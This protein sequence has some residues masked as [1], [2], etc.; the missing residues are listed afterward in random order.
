ME[1]K[2]IVVQYPVG[3]DLS[4]DDY[5]II[6]KESPHFICFPE[7]YFTKN[8]ELNVKTQ[9]GYSEHFQ[10]KIKEYSRE[11]NC[12]IIGGSMI[13]E[14]NGKYFNTCYIYHKGAEIGYYNKINL[15]LHEHENLTPGDTYQVFEVDG[16]RFTVLLCA[17]IFIKWLFKDFAEKKI[18]LIFI[19]TFSPYKEESIE[20]KYKRDEELYVRSA[21]ISHATI[22]KV[23][24][25]GYLGDKRSQGRSLIASQDG[26][27]QRIPPDQ[28]NNK[29]I[30]NQN[31][32]IP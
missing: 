23:C 30:I 17:D 27:I 16:I 20:T 32:V 8:T 29:Q 31:I 4:K 13:T 1:K 19:P 11:F 18:Q 5:N 28:E 9:S 12:T 24:S 25:I 2:I 22:I 21:E 7:Y 10:S 26:I 14:K 3:E 15:F 6:K